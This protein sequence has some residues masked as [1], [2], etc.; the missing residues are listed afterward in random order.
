MTPADLRTARKRL[1]LT[2]HGLAAA[3]RMGKYGWQTIS[4]WENDGSSIPGPVSVAVEAMLAEVQ[5]ATE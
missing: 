2:Q 1:G 4:K 5:R 3:L